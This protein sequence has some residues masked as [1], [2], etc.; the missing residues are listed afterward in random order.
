[1]PPFF[2]NPLHIRETAG[3]KV[4]FRRSAT[5]FGSSWISFIRL[6]WVRR[7][8]CSRPSPSPTDFSPGPTCLSGTK[9]ARGI[10]TEIFAP[11][12]LGEQI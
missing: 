6:E 12:L 8:T 10:R 4:L 11:A 1:M 3:L 7:M 5:S 2:W 9:S